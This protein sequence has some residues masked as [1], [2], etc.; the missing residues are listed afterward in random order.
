MFV[1]HRQNIKFASGLS[2]N[3]IDNLSEPFSTFD[4]PS[5]DATID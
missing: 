2:H 5:E 4:G 3:V 1:C